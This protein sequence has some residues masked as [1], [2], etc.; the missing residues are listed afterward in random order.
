MTQPPCR[1]AIPQPPVEYQTRQT[2]PTQEYFNGLLGEVE[3]AMPT[4]QGYSVHIRTKIQWCNS[5]GEGWY[6]SGGQFIGITRIGA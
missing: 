3:V 5:L 2:R 1:P 6:I 4:E